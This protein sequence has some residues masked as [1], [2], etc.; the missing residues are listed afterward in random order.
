MFDIGHDATTGLLLCVNQKPF[1][2]SSGFGP[3]ESYHSKSEAFLKSK[4]IAPSQREAGCDSNNF[5]PE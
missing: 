2:Q 1:C 4:L 5:I 3:Q